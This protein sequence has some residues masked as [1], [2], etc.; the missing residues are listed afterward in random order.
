MEPIFLIN[1]DHDKKMAA[2][3]RRRGRWIQMLVMSDLFGDEGIAAT[4]LVRLSLF[5]ALTQ[6]PSSIGAGLGK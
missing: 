1:R 6:M 4:D 2:T 5:T 3:S